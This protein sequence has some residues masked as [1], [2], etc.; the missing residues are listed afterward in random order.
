[1]SLEMTRSS[2]SPA[3]VAKSLD[4]CVAICTCS[5]LEAFEAF[6]GDDWSHNESRRRVRPPRGKMDCGLKA[7]GSTHLPIQLQPRMLG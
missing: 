7:I 6:C 1:M 3:G 4:T 5:A 2:V